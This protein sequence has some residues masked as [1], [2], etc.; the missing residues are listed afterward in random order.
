[1]TLTIVD[2]VEFLGHLPLYGVTA[3]LLV[4]MPTEEDQRLGVRRILG[5]VE[6]A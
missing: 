4:W 1:M 5:T 3:V 2:S 6:G